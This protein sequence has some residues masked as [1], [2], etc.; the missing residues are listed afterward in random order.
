MYSVK[1]PS[2]FIGAIKGIDERLKNVKISSVEVDKEQR[3]VTYNFICDKAV[4][5][6]L[7]YKMEETARKF[8]SQ[9]FE[10]VF[11]KVSKIVANGEL[12]VK[13]AYRFLKENYPSVS[14]FMEEDDV[15]AENVGDLV[16][17]ILKLTK[18]GADYV[19]K[20]G[21]LKNLCEFLSKNF[22]ADFVAATDIKSESLAV[23]LLSDEVFE[24]ELEKIEYRTIKV[25]DMLVVD[26][27]VMPQNAVYIEDVIGGGN[28]V[29]NVC[30]KITEI[31][32][33]QT[34]TGKPF[35][36]LHIDDTTGVLSGIYF[37]KKS[38]YDR[39]KKLQQGDAIIAR[40]TLGSYGG[41][42]SFTFEKI[43][44]CTFPDGFVKQDKS[45]KHIPRNYKKIFPT[46]A[47]VMKV[48]TVFD[49][50]A[51]L[52]KELT[53]KT[54]V[55]FDLETTGLD[56]LNNG[57]TE[58]GAVKISGGKISEQFTTLICPEYPITAEISA[59]TGITPD[60]VKDAP[61]IEEVLP[62]F[63]KFTE[64][65]TIVAHNAPFDTGFIRK[66]VNLTGYEFKCLVMDTVELSRKY[67]PELRR[68]DLK[69][70]ADRF[71][72]VFR[73][74]RALSDAYATAEAFI[75]LMKI[76][77]RKDGEN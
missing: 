39:I 26:D 53:D 27:A 30:G 71:N 13:A 56:V 44:F 31:A 66:Y 35:F 63:L 50:A 12:V 41:R 4:T 21:A 36:I 29:Y 45:K 48:S 51:P 58:I 76:K 46:P 74:H 57:I 69:T 2:E 19:T 54:Y 28:G 47:S 43:N 16:K 67:L 5:S 65:T 3:S 37:T 34:K 61:K 24:G 33:R 42:K 59:I 52:P 23:D 22:C 60:M 18:D 64:Y 70:V 6:A 14:I 55:V 25:K 32:E 38:T 75:E 20:N 77:A 68:Y 17:V 49:V 10:K 15:S 40:G 1:D 9:A 72:I 73:H 11:V 62:D 7:C 8:T